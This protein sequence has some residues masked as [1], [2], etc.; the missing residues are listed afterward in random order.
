MRRCSRNGSGRSW[1]ARSSSRRIRSRPSR[2]LARSQSLA[3]TPAILVGHEAGVRFGVQERVGA[4][5]RLCQTG[6]SLTPVRHSPAPS[7]GARVRCVPALESHLVLTARSSAAA[8]SVA[9]VLSPGV[10][11]SVS[12]HAAWPP[13]FVQ[14]DRSAGSRFRKETRACLQ[15]LTGLL[16]KAEFWRADPVRGRWFVRA[17]TRRRCITARAMLAPLR[18]KHANRQTTGASAERP[19][20][21]CS[22]TKRVVSRSHACPEAGQAWH[23][24]GLSVSLRSRWARVSPTIPRV[25]PTPDRVGSPCTYRGQRNDLLDE[26]PVTRLATILRRLSIDSPNRRR[27]EEP[28]SGKRGPHI[29]AHAHLRPQF[30]GGTLFRVLYPAVVHRDQ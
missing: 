22:A 19:F 14:N 20:S 6:A 24:V 10:R 25:P 16:R 29:A 8:W 1:G 30:L 7:Q 27:H 28:H 21:L 13:R 11:H 15:S 17:E 26:D 3:K 4:V 2:R 9:A 18:G 12:C 23:R 5:R